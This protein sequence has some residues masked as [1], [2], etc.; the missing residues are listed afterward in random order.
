MG[1]FKED[2]VSWHS[3]E[4]RGLEA[5]TME[6]IDDWSIMQPTFLYLQRQKGIQRYKK[7]MFG[8]ILCD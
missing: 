4:E 1:I 6:V 5:G 2:T 7:E 8:I 3:C